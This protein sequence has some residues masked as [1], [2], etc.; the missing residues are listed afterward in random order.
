MLALDPWPA[1][2][3]FNFSVASCSSCGA[4]WCFAGAARR[5]IPGEGRARVL[6]TNGP[7]RFTRNPMRLGLAISLSGASILFGGVLLFIGLTL[8][9]VL[10]DRL[11][12]RHEELWLADAFGKAYEAY[13]VCVRRWV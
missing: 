9:I 4:S 12:G 7:Y 13:R 8:F 6:V 10:V 5:L 11:W 2:A 3:L 1:Q